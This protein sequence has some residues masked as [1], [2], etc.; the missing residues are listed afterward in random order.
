[1]V[2]YCIVEGDKSSIAQHLRLMLA[3]LDIFSF[4]FLLFY[5]CDVFSL[6]QVIS[7]FAL[8]CF[9]HAS[10]FYTLLFW[11]SALE[12]TAVYSLFSHGQCFN[13]DM[14]ELHLVKLF[15]RLLQIILVNINTLQFF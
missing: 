9:S 11:F 15:A 12:I 3:L 4:T 10:I 5:I 6:P 2:L 13:Y 14:S 1:M 8:A 7:S